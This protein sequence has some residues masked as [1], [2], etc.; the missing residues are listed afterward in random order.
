ML[1]F[2]FLFL[3]LCSLPSHPDKIWAGRLRVVSC[4]A[5][6]EIRLEDPGW[7]DLFAACFVQSDQPREAAVE[8]VLDSSRYFVLRIEDGRGS[9]RSWVWDLR[10]ETRICG[11][12]IRGAK[13]GSVGLVGLRI[14]G[15][16]WVVVGLLFVGLREGWI[17]GFV[18]VIYLRICGRRWVVVGGRLLWLVEFVVG[19]G[20]GWQSWFPF[21]MILGVGEIRS[22]PI[23][24]D[25]Q[26]NGC[27]FH[28]SDTYTEGPTRTAGGAF[29]DLTSSTFQPH[30]FVDEI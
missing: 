5:R 20:L 21:P 19:C 6:C 14:C 2:S 23:A 30:E 12:G 29:T 9:T 3:C 24:N 26:R 1:S 10:S 4:K 16:R 22:C 28:S 18:F 11:F 17:C 13:R 7:G 15:R 25:R 27:L 8:T